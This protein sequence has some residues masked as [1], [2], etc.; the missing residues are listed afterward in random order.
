MFDR[1]VFATDGSE[2]AL[3][4]QVYARNL[5]KLHKARLFVVHAY[6]SMSDLLGFKDYS[7][8]ATH[9]IARAQK[10]LDEALQSLQGEGVDVESELLEGPTAEAILRV[11][12]ARKA[13]LIILGARGLGTFTGLVLGSVTQKVLH[14]ATC[15]VL[16]VR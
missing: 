4:A 1:I 7:S 11:A 12:A 9:R 14:N 5:A 13:D 16:I 15:P 6:P 2:H 3:K 10:V 8:I